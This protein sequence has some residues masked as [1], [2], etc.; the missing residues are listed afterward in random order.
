MK[1]IYEKFEDYPLNVP[2]LKK[3]SKKLEELIE[4]LKECGSFKTANS[5]YKKWN[6]YTSQLETDM[7]VI[8]VRYTTDVNN[9]VYKRAQ[10]KLSLIHI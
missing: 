10:E 2:S 3:V 4:E 8:M 7:S 9:V 1:A 6:K 5:V